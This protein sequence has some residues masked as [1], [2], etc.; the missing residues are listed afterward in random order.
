MS[1]PAPA[2]EGARRRRRPPCRF[3][4]DPKPLLLL[5]STTV[6]GVPRRHALGFGA[7]CFDQIN[8]LHGW[9]QQLT[10]A[11]VPPTCVH[12][13]EHTHIHTYA[14]RVYASVCP[15]VIHSRWWWC[16]LVVAL[17]WLIAARSACS[18]L[19]FILA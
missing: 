14:R 19:F 7:L 11:R 3:K 4:C 9:L 6:V 17:G 16:A 2:N 15:C 12:V 18:Y 5:Q 10:N 8:C 1:K 13:V